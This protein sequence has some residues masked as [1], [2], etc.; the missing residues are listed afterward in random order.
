MLKKRWR[1]KTWNEI[2]SNMACKRKERESEIERKD[3]RERRVKERV[4]D[5]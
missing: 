5:E 1:R 2:E 4:C 3:V